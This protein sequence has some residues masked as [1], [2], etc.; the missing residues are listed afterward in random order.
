MIGNLVI[1]IND[2]IKDRG[3][4]MR[5]L[6]R[7]A[8]MSPTAIRMV[9]SGQRDPTWNWCAKVA[10]ALR[11]PEVDF[12][13]FAGLLPSNPQNVAE[14]K[15]ILRCY[16]RMTRRAQR[17]FCALA[18]TLADESGKDNEKILQRVVT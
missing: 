13:R 15:E 14:I 10:R 5:E 7:R 3:W 9:L 1:W 17:Q 18:R 4:S 16:D 2:E 12:F 8:D 6:A 11:V